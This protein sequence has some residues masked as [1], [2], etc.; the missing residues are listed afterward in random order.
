M[1]SISRTKSDTITKRSFRDGRALLKKFEVKYD[2]RYLFTYI[3]DI[4]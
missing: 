1:P 2:S 3:G 4:V